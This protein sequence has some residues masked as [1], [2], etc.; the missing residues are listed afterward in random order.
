MQNFEFRM[1]FRDWLHDICA[2]LYHSR[3]PLCHSRVGGNLLDPRS[4]RG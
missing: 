4:L 1:V 3:F 2:L